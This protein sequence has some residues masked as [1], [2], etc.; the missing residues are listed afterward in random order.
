MIEGL[1]FALSI[2]A[3][4]ILYKCFHVCLLYMILADDNHN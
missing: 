3:P 1:D 4:A 2:I